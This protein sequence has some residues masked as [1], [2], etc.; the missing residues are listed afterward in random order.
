MEIGRVPCFLSGVEL[1]CFPWICWV[2]DSPTGTGTSTGGSLYDRDVNCS[3]DGCTALHIA[4]RN[5]YYQTVALL[6]AAPGIDPLARDNVRYT[7]VFR[8][9]GPRRVLVVHSL[10]L[11]CSVVKL[12]L[13]WRGKMGRIPR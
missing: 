1:H 4:A 2:P 6:L 7:A 11:A 5:D 12:H 13:T 3:Q 8:A 10:S 9:H